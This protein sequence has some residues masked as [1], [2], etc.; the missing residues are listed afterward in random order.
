MSGSIL[1]WRAQPNQSCTKQTDAADWNMA[2]PL[3]QRGHRSE[4]RTELSSP[5]PWPSSRRYS[6]RFDELDYLAAIAL[7]E[8]VVAFHANVVTGI[9]NLVAFATDLAVLSRPV[10]VIRKSLARLEVVVS[11]S[12]ILD[13]PHGAIG[14]FDV[15]CLA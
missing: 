2:A 1:W 9:G 4:T 14:Q 15:E 8:K 11:A 13:M 3:R 10:A 12:A 5:G 6:V 7:E